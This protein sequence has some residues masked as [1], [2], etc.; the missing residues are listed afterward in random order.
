KESAKRYS[1]FDKTA[2]QPPHNFSLEFRLQLFVPVVGRTERA[3]PARVWSLVAVESALVIAR[4]FKQAITASVDQGVQRTFCPA[5]KF[6]AHN[7]SA[8]VSKPAFVHHLIDG[9][10]CG[11]SI[12]G[13]DDSF[14]KREAIRFNYNGK[15]QSFAVVQGVAAVGKCPRLS[16]GNSL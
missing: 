10:F 7:P 15:F 16:G 1:L 14:S 11:R 4:R 6:L 12:R 8:C 2:K 9:R 5:Y 3:H 13:N